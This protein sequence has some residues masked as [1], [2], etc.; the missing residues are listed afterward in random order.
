[1]LATVANAAAMQMNRPAQQKSHREQQDV[2]AITSKVIAAA[3]RGD[4]E[5]A[6][7][8][9]L[10]AREISDIGLTN[11][12]V[13]CMYS[14][15]GKKDQAFDALHRAIELGMS[16]DIEQLMR[17]DSDLDNIRDDAR[18]KRALAAASA[19]KEKNARQKSL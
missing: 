12:N 16:Q 18:F 19:A 15:C 6:L 1:M 10:K 17:T 11:Y 4:H 3:Q 14:L 2:G 9:A 7:K 8:L 5:E 13:A